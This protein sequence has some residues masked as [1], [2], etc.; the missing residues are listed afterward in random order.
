MEETTKQKIEVVLARTNYDG[1]NTAWQEF[2]TV[3]IEVDIR[4]EPYWHVVG[5][6]IND[7]P[8]GQEDNWA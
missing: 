7:A 1:A 4:C 2:K 5:E 3:T 8:E 6:R